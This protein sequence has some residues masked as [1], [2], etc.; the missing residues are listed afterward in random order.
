[1]AQN[2][3]AS[4]HGS[5]VTISAT[6]GPFK[7][8]AACGG[9]IATVNI[10]DNDKGPHLATLECDGCGAHTAYLGRDHLAAMLAQR[11]AG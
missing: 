3:Y 11:K 10:T 9:Q 8:C 4:L 1:M 7:S 2:T 5:R 6:A